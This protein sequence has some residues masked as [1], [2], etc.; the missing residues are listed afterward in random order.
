[1]KYPVINYGGFFWNLSKTL[2]YQFFVPDGFLVDPAF[3]FSVLAVWSTQ[4]TV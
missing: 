2:D 1:M 4:F 3:F